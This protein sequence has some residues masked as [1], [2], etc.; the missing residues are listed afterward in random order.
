MRLAVP[1]LV[2]ALLAAGTGRA[3]AQGADRDRARKLMQEAAELLDRRDPKAALAKVEEAHRLY[4]N[5]KTYFNFGVLY[6]E[7]G[8]NVAAFDAYGRFLR[9]ARDASAAQKRSAEDALDG[10]RRTIA[11]LDVQANLDDVM[12]AIDG[13][14]AGRTQGGGAVSVRLNPGSYEVTAEKTGYRSRR[15]SV[16]LA[17][18]ESRRL[19]LALVTAPAATGLPPGP[20]PVSHDPVNPGVGVVE[21]RAPAPSRSRNFVGPGLAVAGLLGLAAGAVVTV[22]SNHEFDDARAAGCPGASMPSVCSAGAD[23]V[24]RLNTISYVFYGAGGLLAA[25]GVGVWIA[26]P[27]HDDPSPRRGLSGGLR[28]TF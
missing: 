18:G 5:P 13:R 27:Y 26:A 2:V 3:Q 21:R 28:G 22:M 7:L 16:L 4:P 6:Q 10:L 9:E 24:Q 11:V 15:E 14:P 20:P 1:V 19:D 17:A 12:V 25:V 8:M 23:K